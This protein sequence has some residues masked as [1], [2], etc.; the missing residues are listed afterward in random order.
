[1]KKSNSSFVCLR[2]LVFVCSLI[3]FISCN[4]SS[5][6][7]EISEPPEDEFSE[8]NEPDNTNY[9]ITSVLSIF[10]SVMDTQLSNYTIGSTYVTITTKDLPDHQSPYYEDTNWEANMFVEN[11]AG[12]FKKNPGSIGEQNVVFNIPLH[13]VAADIKEETPM[14]PMG[15]ARNGVLIFN[16]YAAGRS[17]LDKEIKSFDQ[18]NGHPASTT[19]HYHVEPLA[20]TEEFGEDA[21]LGLLLDGFPLYGPEENGSVLSSEDLD[22]YH[23]HYHDTQEF[24]DGIYHYHVTA[25]D[26][27][28]NGD[29]FYGEVGNL[30]R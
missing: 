11:T 5:E 25:T 2:F 10:T 18:Y 12:G 13:P 8:G 20:L 21:I 29:G 14:G 9:D 17:A 22:E 7:L 30:T 1:M 27:Y 26:P 28:I 19:Y 4:A 15:I 23:G 6:T 3:F 24:P 16:Q